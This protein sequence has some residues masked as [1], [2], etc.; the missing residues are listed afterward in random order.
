MG[1]ELLLFESELLEDGLVDLLVGLGDGDAGKVDGE[2]A[3]RVE[4]ESADRLGE[5]VLGLV[6]LLVGDRE[7]GFSLRKHLNMKE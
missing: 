1:V 4:Q 5:G 3:G 2:P 6:V 7:H